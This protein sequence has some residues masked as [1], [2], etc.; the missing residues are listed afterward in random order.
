M[1]TCKFT[2]LKAEERETNKGTKNRNDA[3]RQQSLVRTGTSTLPGEETMGGIVLSIKLPFVS[4]MPNY[5]RHALRFYLR[6]VRVVRG[7]QKRDACASAKCAST[8]G[9]LA[10]L[11]NS[12]RGRS[13]YD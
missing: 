3:T 6:I 9:R 11:D 4:R 8:T 12:L 10:R 5:P 13:T 7:A 1:Q 2:Q